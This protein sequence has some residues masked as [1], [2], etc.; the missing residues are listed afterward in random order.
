MRVYVVRRW[1]L[2]G[3]SRFV[4]WNITRVSLC[5]LCNVYFV[6]STQ[7][8]SLETIPFVRGTNSLLKLGVCAS[9]NQVVAHLPLKM[10]WKVFGPVFCTVIRNQRELQLRS[11]RCRKQQCG[12][13]CLSVWCLNHTASKWYNKCWMKITGAGLISVYSYKT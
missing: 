3:R 7:R 1:P 9:R 8:T 12:G 13:F 10:T 11:Y 6:Q 2:R 5:L 4:C